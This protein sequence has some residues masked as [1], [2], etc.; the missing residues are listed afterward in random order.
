MLIFVASLSGMPN[1]TDHYEE[2]PSPFLQDDVFTSDQVISDPLP[3]NMASLVKDILTSDQDPS[4]NLPQNVANL[5]ERMLR[6][7]DFS[8]SEEVSVSYTHLSCRRRG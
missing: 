5:V 2:P 1:A 6:Q 8:A 4:D 3:M 7:E